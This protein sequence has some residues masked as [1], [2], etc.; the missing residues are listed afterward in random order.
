MLER[1]LPGPP[2]LVGLEVKAPQEL[3]DRPGASRG[4]TAL[5]AF[6]AGSWRL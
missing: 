1:Q 2:D 5:L 6:A 3:G 4:L